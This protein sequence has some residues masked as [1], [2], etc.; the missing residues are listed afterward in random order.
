MGGAGAE[1]AADAAD[2]ESGTGRISHVAWP[3]YSRFRFQLAL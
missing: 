2:K 1:D 3:A